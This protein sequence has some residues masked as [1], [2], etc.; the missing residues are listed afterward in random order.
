MKPI[1]LM[2]VKQALRDKRFRE[3]LPPIFDADVQKYLQNLK[4]EKIKSHLQPV[5]ENISL[6]KSKLSKDKALIGFSGSPFTLACYMIEGGSSKNFDLVKF[7]VQPSKKLE[8]S[9]KDKEIEI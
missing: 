5:F 9:F 3:S 7:L 1:G 2:D 6:T 8:I 4:I